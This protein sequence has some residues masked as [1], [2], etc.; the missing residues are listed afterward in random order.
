MEKQTRHR[1]N[2]VLLGWILPFLFTTIVSGQENGQRRPDRSKRAVDSIRKKD[3]IER[4]TQTVF[5]RSDSSRRWDSAGRRWDSTGRRWDSTGRRWD[6]TGRRWD[7]AGR[8]SDSGRARGGLISSLFADSNSLTT[9]DYQLQVEKTFLSLNNIENN[10]QLG[11]AVKNT[12]DKLTESTGVLAVLKDNVL[13]N[14]T[15]LNLKN[16]QVFKTLLQN[17]Q[18][19]LRGER[20]YLDSNENK[21]VRLRSDLRQLISDTVLRQLMRN[22]SLRADFGTQLRDL[23]RAFLRTTRQVR[24]SMTAINLL[25]TQTSSN[26]I[27]TNQLLEDIDNLEQSSARRIFSKENNYLWE[28]DTTELTEQKRQSFEKVYEGE[29]K[30]MGYYFSDNGYK[31]I[32]LLFLGLLYYLWVFRNIKYLRTHKGDHTLTGNEFEYLKYGVI[33]SALVVIF[34][35]APMFD[36]HAPAAYIETM[37]FFLL[38]AVT[39]LMYKKWSGAIFRWWLGL[40]LLFICFSLTSHTIEPGSLR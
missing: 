35:I 8:R 24:E 32:L 12:Q 37:Q 6:S 20:K 9:S 7:S 5:W 27:N 36:L 21:M 39:Y 16:L 3:S 18:K 13:N 10:S 33:A 17:I 40:A 19:D 26:L 1:I 22:D 25:Q 2:V 34:A 28:A 38:C 29:K 15:A 31:T 14:N 11:P 23:R 30:A 4:L